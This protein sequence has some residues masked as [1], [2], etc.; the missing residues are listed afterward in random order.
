[1]PRLALLAPLGALLFTLAWVV[2][3]LIS[4]G[5][6]LFDLVIEPYSPIAQPVSGLG[7]GVTGPYMNAAFVVSGLLIA[8]GAVGIRS[9]WPAVR[10][11]CGVPFALAISGVGLVIDGLFTLESVMPHLVGFL[12]AV[13]GA[14]VG[15]AI[16]AVALRSTWRTGSVVVGVA[17]AAALGLFV[18]FMVIFDPYSAGDNAGVAGLVQRLLI[19]VVLGGIAFLPLAL[20]TRALV[21]ARR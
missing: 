11:R 21:S 1:M 17:A 19:T 9:L 20:R 7:L 10:G 6:Q 15:F 14:V 8:A 18:V 12:L 13:G 16:A 3:G 4:P 2:L 5:Y